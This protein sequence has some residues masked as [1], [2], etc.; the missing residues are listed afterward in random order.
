MYFNRLTMK[1]I[2]A[3]AHETAPIGQNN[4]DLANDEDPREVSLA[5][6]DRITLNFPKAALVTTRGRL[7]GPDGV[8]VLHTTVEAYV[9]R[10]GVPD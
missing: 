9:R 3:C 7:A 1:V 8:P 10:R 2:A 5:G 4:L 6:V